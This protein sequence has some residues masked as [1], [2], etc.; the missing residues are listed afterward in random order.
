MT[1]WTDPRL[2][3]L[4]L[5]IYYFAIL[6]GIFLVSSRQGFSPPAFVYQGF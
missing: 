4:A 3:F 6:I 1:R 2:R 5:T